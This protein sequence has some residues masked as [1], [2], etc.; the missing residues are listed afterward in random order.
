MCVEVKRRFLDKKEAS[1]WLANNAPV[2]DAE[3]IYTV[4]E[5]Y[6][7]WSAVHYAK[8]SKKKSQAYSAAYRNCESIKNRSWDSL[9]L[10]ELQSCVNLAKD[11][12][13]QRKAVKI[14]LH[15]IEDY[16]L[17]NE[18]ATKRMT[19]FIEIPAEVKPD[20]HP[21]TREEIKK[22][23]DGYNKGI[24][25]AGAVLIMIHTGMRYGEITTIKPE[26]IHLDEGYL[27]GGIKTAA[28]KEGEILILDAIKP[29]VKDLML[30]MNE[31]GQ[32]SQTT[33]VKNFNKALEE[34]G[35]GHHTTHEC[36]H[37]TA[38]LLAEEG[39]QPG[40]IKEIMRHTN[41]NQSMQYTHISRKLKTE[42]LNKIITEV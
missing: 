10:A 5:L 32:Y 23:F 11:S 22:L 21:F 41:Y 38:T 17:K 9:S 28:G 12:H 25:F 26:N 8:I 35:C 34:C 7:G 30:P 39:V 37:T 18:Y 16:A 24:R 29:M 33:F 40:I 19:E 20:K 14:V 13:N 6:E 27:M 1:I 2:L 31:L 4:Q 42:E 36:R 15:Q 3:K